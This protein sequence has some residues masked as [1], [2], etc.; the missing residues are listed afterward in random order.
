MEAGLLSSYEVIMRSVI[1]LISINRL[2]AHI[3][4]DGRKSYCSLCTYLPLP[5]I[6]PL[7]TFHAFAPIVTMSLHRH[8]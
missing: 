6:N 8:R 3:S 1:S 5:G 2:V 7:C 4:I